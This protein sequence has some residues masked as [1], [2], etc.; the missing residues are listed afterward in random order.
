[1]MPP[2]EIL[3]NVELDNQSIIPEHVNIVALTESLL[4]MIKEGH[5]QFMSM[6]LC[7]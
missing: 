6:L 2:V 5:A 4:D 3:P 1:M 7:F